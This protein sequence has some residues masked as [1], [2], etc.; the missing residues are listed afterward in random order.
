MLLKRRRALQ[1]AHLVFVDG[2]LKVHQ[3]HPDLPS[4]SQL[5]C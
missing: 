4:R 1:D 3:C 2:F 5:K